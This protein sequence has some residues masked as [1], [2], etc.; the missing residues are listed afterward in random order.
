LNNKNEIKVGNTEKNTRKKK[1]KNTGTPMMT[2]NQLYDPHNVGF[3]R[4]D[5]LRNT[6]YKKTGFE[7]VTAHHFSQHTYDA[8]HKHPWKNPYSHSTKNIQHSTQ[9]HQTHYNSTQQDSTY[10]HSTQHP[11]S[12]LPSTT[13]AQETTPASVETLAT[14]KCT[15]EVSPTTI[16]T[17]TNNLEQR[18]SSQELRHQQSARSPFDYKPES[19]YSC[20]KTALPTIDT[21]FYLSE[22]AYQKSQ[23]VCERVIQLCNQDNEIGWLYSG[24]VKKIQQQ[25]QRS[26]VHIIA[27]D[28]V[29]A[30]NQKIRF[31][32]YG[33]NG[34]EQTVIQETLFEKNK[35]IV[36]IGHSHCTFNIFHSSIDISNLKLLPLT[37]G[38]SLEQTHVLPSLVFNAKK[39]PIDAQMAYIT[40][41]KMDMKKLEI[42]WEKVESIYKNKPLIETDEQKQKRLSQTLVLPVTTKLPIQTIQ[43]QC[44]N[45]APAPAQTQ[46][47]AVEK[48]NCEKTTPS[49]AQKQTAC[50]QEKVSDDLAELH[51]CN[52]D[53]F[54]K[55]HPIYFSEF[56]TN[57]NDE[58]Q[59][60]HLAPTSYNLINDEEQTQLDTSICRILQRNNLEIKYEMLGSRK[61]KILSLLQ[62]EN[63]SRTL[64]S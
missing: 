2:Y 5:T 33:I 59:K 45:N 13:T 3:I 34:S 15:S 25:G 51:Q 6:H 56:N 43:Q 24:T 35:R 54:I 7:L 48:S 19:Y 21:Y 46:S 31:S 55:Q 16:P 11:D 20:K 58:F 62:D 57:E 10:Q 64:V 12:K 39:D 50:A 9:K 27:E 52:R 63:N 14:Q 22:K 23:Y 17:R 32:S 28:I 1:Q 18:A 29:L 49:L 8:I 47:V 30:E 40:N 26:A 41:S 42:N 60:R 4:T 37:I 61:D 53:V 44:A 38:I 36:G